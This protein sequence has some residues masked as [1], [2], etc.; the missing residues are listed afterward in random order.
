MCL[1]RSF[2]FIDGDCYCGLAERATRIVGGEDT[3]VNEYPWQAG[4]VSRGQHDFVWCGGSLVS[5][6]WVITAAHC[7][8]GASARDI[9]VRSHLSGDIC[10]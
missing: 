9:E 1:K 6:R 2:T 4:L 8:A 7:T 5:S 3:E 10:V